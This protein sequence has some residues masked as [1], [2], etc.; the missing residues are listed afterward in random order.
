MKYI[1]VI[2]ISLLTISCQSQKSNAVFESIWIEKHACRG[3]CPAY[4][5][6]VQKD[7]TTVLNG[8]RYYF[9]KMPNKEEA[10][11][12]H[13]SVNSETLNAIAAVAKKFKEADTK[14]E[15]KDTKTDQSGYRI[16]VQYSDG[17]SK[18]VYVYGYTNIQSIHN[19]FSS[20]DDLRKSQT[21][22][23]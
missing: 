19:L 15:Y 8:E 14:E 13:T 7:G 22:K 1:F 4:E 11:T 6:T 21:W 9:D 2:L 10:G 12:Y 18:K 3:F 20:L 5:M 23:K 17:T 16:K